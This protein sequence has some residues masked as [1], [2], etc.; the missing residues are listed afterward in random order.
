[1]NIVFV[2]LLIALAAFLPWTLVRTGCWKE[3]LAAIGASAAAIWGG[4]QLL[5]GNLF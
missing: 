4:A 2:I 5:F 1:M 3:A